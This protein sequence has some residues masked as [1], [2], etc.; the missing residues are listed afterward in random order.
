MSDFSKWLFEKYLDYQREMGVPRS[1]T[2]FGAYVGVSGDIMRL[3][4]K[5]K[6]SPSD[7]SLALLAAKFGDDVYRVLGRTPPDPLL[8]D[9][10]A[11]WR[12]LPQE[13]KDKIIEVIHSE[14]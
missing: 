1:V 2:A 8:E 6:R 7:S 14:E 10:N 9:V 12:M 13:K 4:F 3:W 11:N 5:D